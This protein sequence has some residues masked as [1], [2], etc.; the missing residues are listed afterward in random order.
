M[1]TE[2]TRELLDHELKRLEGRMEELVAASVRLRSDNHSL[3]ERL[4]S[5]NTERAGLLA[6]NEQVRGRVEAMITR[7]KSLEESA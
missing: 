2:K 4:E 3:R 1:Q 6:K 7:L 5:M